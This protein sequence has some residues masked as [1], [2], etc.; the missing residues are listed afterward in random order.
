MMFSAVKKSDLNEEFRMDSEYYSPD[1][2]K[3]E[4]VVLNH[5]HKYLGK[6]CELIAGPFGSTVTTERYDENSWKRYIRGKDIQSFFIDD[7]DPVFI[8]ERLFYELPQF[9]LKENDILLTVVG[10]KFGKV[11][12][13]SREDLPSI[14]SCKSTLIRNTEINPWYLLAYLSCSVGYGLV[15]RGQRGA[16]QPG[17]NLFDIRTVPVPLFSDYFQTKIEHTIKSAKDILG[18]SSA[19]FTLSQEFLLSEIGLS[20]WQP[21]RQ[22][23]FIKNYSDIKQAKRVDAE[24]YQP[25]YDE[26]I[27][28]I[29][30]YSGGWETLH[31]LVH[32]K[33]SI[34][35]GSCEYLDEGVPFV[36][37]SNISPFDISE[38]KYISESLYRQL[39]PEEKNVPFTKSKNHQPQQGEILLS[40]DGTPGIA[41]Y[42]NEQPPKMIPSGGILRLKSKT[43]IV[44]DEYLTLVLNSMLTQEQINRDV[45]GSII[46]HWRPDQV[47]QTVIPILSDIK[48]FKI[49]QNVIESFKLRKRSEYLLECAKKT[50]EIAIQKDEQAAIDWLESQIKASSVNNT[51]G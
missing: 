42:L 22:I 23:T 50:V 30:K 19:S 41:H 2:L 24:Y 44:N 35:V 7:T 8:E 10:M 18:K 13:I 20:N 6:L 26:I 1:N 9:H 47:K 27:N 38:E 25:K 49:Q 16:A 45:A 33:K 3:K 31:S 46:L 37:V 40:K 11:A 34:E 17:I 32:M 51:H 48:Q 14:F 15:R 29:K 5:K 21:K 12:I 28:A 36:R 43:D 39:T 4:D